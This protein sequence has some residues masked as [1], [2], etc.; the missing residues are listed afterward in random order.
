MYQERTTKQGVIAVIYYVCLLAAFFLMGVLYQKNVAYD[1]LYWLLF[2]VPVLFVLLKDR[3]MV[4]LGFTKTRLKSNLLIA[5]A[6]IAVSVVI[7][8]LVSERPANRLLYGVFYYL[9]RIALVEE[10]LFRGFIQNYLFGFKQ[11]RI[12]IYLLGALFFAVMHLPF[13]MYVN[14]MVSFDYVLTAAPQ[15][16][17]T[18]VFHLVMCLIAA[19]RNDI[20]IPIALHFA[21]DYIQA[22]I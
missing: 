21:I 22:V 2:A 5:A 10:V 11:N 19:K 7:A 8:F 16:C 4:D 9:V 14:E 17:F 15:L 18:F 1:W 6:M 20:I 13:Q 12:V 3:N